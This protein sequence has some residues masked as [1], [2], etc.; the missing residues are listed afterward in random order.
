MVIYPGRICSKSPE[1]KQKL[2]ASPFLVPNVIIKVASDVMFG[3]QACTAKGFLRN[4]TILE[5]K[6]NSRIPAFLLF[7]PE[8]A[9][10]MK[11][12][13][14]LQNSNTIKSAVRCL[15]W[16]NQILPTIKHLPMINQLKRA[17][18]F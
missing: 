3:L 4:R 18:W 17:V 6:K 11:E 7:V 5:I 13:N 16:F 14:K 2:K 10:T 15:M 8:I 1:N 12:T 9:K